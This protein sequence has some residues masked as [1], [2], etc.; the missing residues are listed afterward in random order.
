MNRINDENDIEEDEE[1]IYNESQ[2]EDLQSDFKFLVLNTK[3][4]LYDCI[5]KAPSINSKEA[6][7]NRLLIEYITKLNILYQLC[8]ALNTSTVS[9][10]NI[11]TKL[12]KFPIETRDNI[13]QLIL[14][15]ST[16]LST[17]RCVDTIPYN[18]YL[19]IQLIRH[20]FLQK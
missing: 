17:N 16:F 15:L 13:K 18:D 19:E 11:E 10:K 5:I 2:F 3:R 12:F 6:Q 1:F 8:K 4:Q 20:P 9:M 7:D 14:W